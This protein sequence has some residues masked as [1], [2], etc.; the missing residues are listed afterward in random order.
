MCTKRLEVSKC[1]SPTQKGSRSKA[2]NYLSVSLT[3]QICK[4]MESL[5]CASI[6][7]HV[8]SK[9]LF[10]IDQHGFTGRRL[11]LLNLLETLEIWTNAME[12]GYGVDVIY[13]DY[14][15]AFYTVP[16]KRLMQKLKGYGV[17]GVVAKWL[18]DL[19]PERKIRV[20]V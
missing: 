15:K 4:I 1:G 14:Q 6:L 7:E 9:E 18:E 19:F 10:S 13:L 3:S 20:G 17:K 5:V 8:D 2:D 16:I 12:E 11:F